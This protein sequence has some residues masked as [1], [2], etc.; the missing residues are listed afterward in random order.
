MRVDEDG[1]H[2]DVTADDAVF[3]SVSIDADDNITFDIDDGALKRTLQRV[4][5]TGPPSG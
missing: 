1:A 2:G 5:G 3:G 4:L